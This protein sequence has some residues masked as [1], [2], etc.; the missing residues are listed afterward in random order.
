[1][2]FPWQ[3]GRQCSLQLL[4]QPWICAPGSHYGWVD[5]GSVGYEVCP[6]L[7]HIAS[8]GNRTPDL[9]ILSPTPYPLG[10]NMH[11]LSNIS[12]YLTCKKVKDSA[13][14]IASCT[15]SNYLFSS[16]PVSAP[17]TLPRSYCCCC[18]L[19]LLSRHCAGDAGSTSKIH[20]L[21]NGKQMIPKANNMQ[22]KLFI[23]FILGLII[24]NTVAVFLWSRRLY[25]YD[26]ALNV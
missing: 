25:Y 18:C 21:K 13:V 7:L 6:T 1:M 26:Q 22:L 16:V 23:K 14:Y 24:I 12:S 17:A 9:L 20:A 2:P 5:R 8:N 3:G 4:I 15:C 10:H 11:C 19:L